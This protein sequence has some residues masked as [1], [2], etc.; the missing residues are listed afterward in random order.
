M[1]RQGII[2]KFTGVDD[3]YEE[4]AHPEMVVETDRMTIDVSVEGII[5]FLEERRY[6]V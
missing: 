6:I 2:K 4:P 5:R 3:P 1:A